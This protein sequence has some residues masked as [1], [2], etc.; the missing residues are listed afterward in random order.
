MSIPITVTL[1][2]VGTDT[3]P[4][5]LYSNTDG[6]INSFESNID[7]NTLLSGFFTNNTPD[8]TTIV[9]VMSNNINCTSY[10]DISI[11]GIIPSTPTP[12]PTPPVTPT[13]T[14]PNPL[15]YATINAKDRLVGN[16]TW[17]SDITINSNPVIGM[18]YP[19]T[20]YIDKSGTTTYF[21]SSSVVVIEIVN[22]IDGFCISIT[23][24]NNSI[25]TI[26]V[27]S[28]TTTYT[29]TGV[30]INSTDTIEIL[31]TRDIC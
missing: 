11:S 22:P 18:N 4:F 13:P 5:N 26:S 17:I 30:S 1:T 14:P 21:D 16:T 28:V 29:F 3:S 6:F 7:K 31:Y 27:V 20:I 12:T 25:Q 8:N 10:I 24:G 19:V 2:S 15:D 23:D 9:R